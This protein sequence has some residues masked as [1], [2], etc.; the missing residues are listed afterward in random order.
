MNLG[1]ALYAQTIDSA[2]SKLDQYPHF[3]R[4]I[5]NIYNSL[6]EDPN[7]DKNYFSYKKSMASSTRMKGPRVKRIKVLTDA[8]DI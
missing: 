7:S 2:L 3:G 5:N 8:L 4:E 6:R 1:E